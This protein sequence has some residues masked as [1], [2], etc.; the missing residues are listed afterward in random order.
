M[1]DDVKGRIK[2]PPRDWDKAAEELILRTLV[3]MDSDFSHISTVDLE[4]RLLRGEEVV[5]WMTNWIR[6]Q[7]QFIQAINT[8]DFAAFERLM[9]DP[10][11]R[12]V[13]FELLTDQRR[14]RQGRQKGE[15]PLPERIQDALASA[16]A[17][18]PIIRTIC[19]E[20]GIRYR[21]DNAI[22]LSARRHG[23]HGHQQLISYL[24]NKSRRHK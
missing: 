16:A 8:T 19:R 24:K 2:P 9:E 11:L 10:E 13:V 12:R 23:L 4:G 1:K 21:R 7:S 6:K 5:T 3:Q 17:D 18:I 20:N 22:E 14:R 15:S